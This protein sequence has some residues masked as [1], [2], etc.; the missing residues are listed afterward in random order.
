MSTPA[1]L[2]A[3]TIRRPSGV[4][5]WSSSWQP[6]ATL[7]LRFVREMHL[8]HAEV[9]VERHHGRL[10]Q[11]RHRAFE[12]EADR[13]LAGGRRAFDVVDMRRNDIP[14]GMPP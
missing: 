12:I 13:E 10:L 3:A 6:P 8:P 9:A 4:K 5:P 2:T 11:Q 14:V 7:L 1:S